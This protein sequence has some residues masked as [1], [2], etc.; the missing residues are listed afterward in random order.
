MEI[1][2]DIWRYMEIYGDIW[3]YM[4]IYGDIWRYGMLPEVWVLLE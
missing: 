4:E 3:R 2:G 1:Y